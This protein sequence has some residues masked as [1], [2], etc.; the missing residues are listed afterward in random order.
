MNLVTRESLVGNQF[1]LSS[2]RRD[3]MFAASL[4]SR[5]MNDLS[6]I[7][8]GSEKRILRYI[9]G[10]LDY[11]IKYDTKVETKLI[12]YCDNDLAG[13]MDDMK[14]NLGNVFSLG[15]GVVLWC[16]KK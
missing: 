12:C 8:L 4:L 5:F 16:S 10:T 15:L 11:W 7:H 13:Y 6:H 2:T 3:I 1:Y 14:R 9:Q